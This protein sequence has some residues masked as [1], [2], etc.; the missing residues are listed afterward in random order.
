MKNLQTPLV[1]IA[2]SLFREVF[3]VALPMPTQRDRD[4]RIKDMNSRRW[5]QANL[6][7][8]LRSRTAG[9]FEG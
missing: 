2:H 8:I 6:Y 3:L 4:S 7:S 1:S 5:T 9:H